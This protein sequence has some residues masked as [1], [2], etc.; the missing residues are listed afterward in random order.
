M[1][2]IADF[3]FNQ[4]LLSDGVVLVSQAIRRDF[5]AQDVRQNLQQLVESARSAIPED[6]EQDLQLEKLI[7]LFYHT[8]IR[9]CG[10]RLSPV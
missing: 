6:L 9:R 2:A 10:R 4:S 1:S 7:E 5:P 8:G 3:E